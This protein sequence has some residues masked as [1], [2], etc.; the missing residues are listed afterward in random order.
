MLT[1]KWVCSLSAEIYIFAVYTAEVLNVINVRCDILNEEVLHA[2][3]LLEILLPRV[4][5]YFVAPLYYDHEKCCPLTK[6]TKTCYPPLKKKK[7][8]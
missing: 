3:A 5:H 8:C 2:E 4:G 1:G 6:K 7:P